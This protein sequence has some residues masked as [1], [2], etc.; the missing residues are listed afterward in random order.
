MTIDSRIP[1]GVPTGGQFASTQKTEASSDVLNG[2]SQWTPFGRWTVVVEDQDE[3][4]FRPQTTPGRVGYL[5]YSGAGF[6]DTTWLEATTDENG[7][8]AVAFRSTYYGEEGA[9]EIM[10]LTDEE[11]AGAYS[12]N[13]TSR[14]IDG[15]CID[16]QTE[17]D[18]TAF[19]PFFTPNRCGFVI[20]HESGVRQVASI[21]PSTGSDDGV[22]T[23]FSYFT[24]EPYNDDLGDAFSHVAFFDGED[25]EAPD[26]RVQ[27]S[28]LEEDADVDC[29]LSW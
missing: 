21:V 19:T 4:E 3:V 9:D 7:N 8:P 22:V 24:D 26:A 5:A 27:V 29:D 28:D 13:V 15:L 10:P 2:A 6:T 25:V 18:G 11:K 1:A 14:I 23:A 16:L 12:L 17:V 20:D